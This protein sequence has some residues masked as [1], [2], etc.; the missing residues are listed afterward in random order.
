[1]LPNMSVP[2]MLASWFLTQK[3]TWSFDY[4][5]ILHRMFV[6]TLRRCCATEFCHCLYK[7][8]QISLT[9]D[10][11]ISS[12]FVGYFLHPVDVDSI[13]NKLYMY[14]YV[15]VMFFY[16]GAHPTN[17]R[18]TSMS[19]GF[20]FQLLST[21]YKKRRKP[22]VVLEGTQIVK[23]WSSTSASRWESWWLTSN[24]HI[25]VFTWTKIIYLLKLH[26]VGLCHVC[27]VSLKNFLPLQ[28][29]FP[30]VSN[31]NNKKT[32]VETGAPARWV[33]CLQGFCLQRVL[34]DTHWTHQGMYVHL[35]DLQNEWWKICNR[36]TCM[37]FIH[38]YLHI[39]SY[40]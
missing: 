23:M 27:S 18:K 25:M 19:K 34:I 29:G 7:S 5:I 17:I 20:I 38:V 28:L 39:W 1:M 31:N 33:N 40:L 30:W 24:D 9:V 2:H 14:M 35:L 36:V 16:Q 15:Y 10:K 22:Q 6:R 32:T 11:K 26:L 12:L 13:T 4:T 3:C 21:S 8:H 37:Q